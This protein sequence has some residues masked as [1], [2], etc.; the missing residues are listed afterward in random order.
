MQIPLCNYIALLAKF[1]T[2]SVARLLHF[3]KFLPRFQT[4]RWRFFVVLLG[5]FW[6]TFGHIPSTLEWCACARHIYHFVASL[7]LICLHCSPR[8][9]IFE[10]S[11]YLCCW[12]PRDFS[13]DWFNTALHEF[14]RRL[15][16][17]IFDCAS[18][19]KP[20][21]KETNEEQKLEPVSPVC[22][23]CL[24]RSP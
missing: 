15:V 20:E 2:R 22:F 9:R 4:K 13:S 3:V 24:Q 14:E 17:K 11:A 16:C 1:F 19:T 8:G 12:W 6:Q 23:V 10:W 18:S 21:V 7:Q 5:Y